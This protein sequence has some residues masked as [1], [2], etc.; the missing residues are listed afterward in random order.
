MAV[1]LFRPKTSTS[2][3][4]W[5]Q[6]LSPQYRTLRNV[7][8]WLIR[9]GTIAGVQAVSVYPGLLLDM[10]TFSHNTGRLSARVLVVTRVNVFPRIACVFHACLA[11]RALP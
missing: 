3:P 5:V 10:V 1:V 8:P 2:T 11:R 7:A 6:L 4:G 9:H